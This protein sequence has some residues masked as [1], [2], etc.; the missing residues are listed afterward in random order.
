MVRAPYAYLATSLLLVACGV[1]CLAWIH[2]ASAAVLAQTAAAPSTSSAAGSGLAQSG[3]KP[4]APSNPVQASS[5]V[6]ASSGSAEKSGEPVTP[7]E[8]KAS[9]DDFKWVLTLILGVAGLFTVVQ[10]IAAGFSAQNFQKQAEGIFANLEKLATETK[11][12]YPIFS[13]T[14]DRRKLAYEKLTQD[15]K[16]TSA[17]GSADE[18]IDWRRQFYEKMEVADRQEILSFERFV[19]FEFAS[20]SEAKETFAVQLRRLAHFYWSKFICELN[21]GSGSMADLERAEYLLMMAT[22]KIGEQFYLCNDLGN[23]RLEVLKARKKALGPDFTPDAKQEL[24]ASAKAIKKVFEDGLLLNREQIRAHYNI[25][26]VHGEFLDDVD[27]AI[28]WLK[29]G[30]HYPNW[31]TRPVKDFQCRAFFNLACFLGRKAK[32]DASLTPGQEVLNALHRAASIGATS[33]KDVEKEYGPEGDF[34]YL[35]T[36]GDA[37]TQKLLASLKQQLSAHAS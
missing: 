19:G 25:A 35:L 11:A 36:N 1:V 29:K 17:I 14:E 2:S 20:Q 5:S 4:S 32:T 21:Y 24:T 8:L 18:G 31:E 10:G 26:W 23:V 16:K 9:I 28:D 15:L 33:K 27:G 3:T 34:Y 7:D 6:N 37:T 22:H 12:R 30:V 13:D